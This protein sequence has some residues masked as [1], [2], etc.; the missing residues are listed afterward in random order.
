M[1]RPVLEYG[2]ILY[3]NCTLHQSEKLESIQRKA[4]LICSG[5]YRHTEH[6]TLLSELGWEPLSIRRHIQKLTMYF[7]MTHNL[8]PNYLSSLT[9]NIKANIT[10]YRLRNRDDRIIP[11]AR[12]VMYQKSLLPSSTKLWN[13]MPAQVRNTLLLNSFKTKLKTLFAASKQ[14]YHTMYK[15]KPGIWLARL[16]MGLSA[17]N[18][19]RFKY[20]FIASPTCDHC[21]SGN[22]T[23]M[24]YF[25]LC[26]A[27]AASRLELLNNLDIKLGID[28][29]NRQ[30]MLNIILHGTIPQ[31]HLPTLTEIVTEYITKTERFK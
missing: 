19:H 11:K 28:I 15:S 18:S 31:E 6:K 1:I 17:L 10:N 26:P 7:K 2:N 25:F 4:A 22:E 3:D 24:H 16:R 29:F 8:V 12:T 27:Y 21:H 30:E 14:K 23:T 9:T 5:A 13:S 20:N